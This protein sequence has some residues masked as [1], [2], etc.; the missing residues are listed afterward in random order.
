MDSLSDVDTAALVTRVRSGDQAAWTALTDRYSS[1][2]WSVARGMRLSH[3]DAAD[4]VQ[5]TWLRLVESLD[6]L[7]EP[8]RLGAWLATTIRREA[9]ATLRRSVRSRPSGLPAWEDIPAGGD[10]LDAALLREERD[11]ALWQAFGRLSPR[12]QALLRVLI[13]DPAP[14]YAEVAA[15]L[16]IPVGSIG[17]TRQ[18]CLGVLRTV[19]TSVADLPGAPPAGNP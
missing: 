13:A 2:L 7:R 5:T 18:R 15:A 10:P 6:N 4:A 12:C 8:E 14:S 16:D 17:P 11:V 3:A 1:L 19:M 9:L